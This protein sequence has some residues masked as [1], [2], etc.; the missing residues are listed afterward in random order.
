VTIEAGGKV[1]AASETIRKGA[2]TLSVR[3]T[4]GAYVFFCSVD[5]HRVAGMRGTLTAR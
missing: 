3:L 2:T 4:P 1:I 5:G